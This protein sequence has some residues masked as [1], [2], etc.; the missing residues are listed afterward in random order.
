MTIPPVTV[1][2]PVFTGRKRNQQI[3]TWVFVDSD[4]LERLGDIALRLGTHGYAVIRGAGR[5]LLHRAI[6]GL[7]DGDGRVV[8]HINRD[9]LNCTQRNLRVGTQAE[10]MQN[11]PRSPYCGTS[12]NHKR[13]CAQIKVDGESRYLGTYDTREEAA[14][15]ARAARVEHYAF[16]T[17]SA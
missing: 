11:L 2:L 4:A 13:W 16:T 1:M 14:A 10:N 15:V 6:V 8:D 9:R 12:R 3:A 7:T 17:E 5:Q